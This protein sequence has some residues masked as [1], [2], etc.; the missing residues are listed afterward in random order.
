MRFTTGGGALNAIF[1]GWPEG[2]VTIAALGTQA[3]G[4]IERATLLGGGKVAIR[5]TADGLI[6]TLPPA[7]AGAMLPVVRLEGPGLV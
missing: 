3:A 5:R 6:L 7:P 2:P 4:R 1:L